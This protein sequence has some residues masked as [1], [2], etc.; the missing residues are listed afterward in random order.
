[1]ADQT[2]A[3]AALPDLSLGAASR[4]VAAAGL[5]VEEVSSN[6]VRGHLDLGPEHH[7]PWGVVHGGVH[8]AA[9]ESAASIGATAAVA[10]RGQYAVGL[11]NATDFLRASTNGRADVL[12]EPL[13][14]GRSQQ[15]WLVTITNQQG[16][17]LARGQLRLQNI[18]RKQAPKGRS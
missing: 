5:V 8:T 1:M 7:T 11:H 6:R 18:S 9:V 13:H 16:E 15:L 4:F 2:A 12:A 14:Q 10:D 3:S 17:Q